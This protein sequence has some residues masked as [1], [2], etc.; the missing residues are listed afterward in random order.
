M[1]RAP[2]PPRQKPSDWLTRVTPAHRNN[3]SASLVRNVFVLTRCF[4]ERLKNANLSF[5][6]QLKND[7]KATRAGQ[8]W[9]GVE[10]KR[11]QYLLSNQRTCKFPENRLRVNWQRNSVFANSVSYRLI[12]SRFTSLNYWLWEC[13]Y[14]FLSAGI[15]THPTLCGRESQRPLTLSKIYALLIVT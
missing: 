11:H 2:T 3:F 13:F 4:P 8:T 15:T 6:K 12:E 1:A 7:L 14:N 9:S 10:K 5:R